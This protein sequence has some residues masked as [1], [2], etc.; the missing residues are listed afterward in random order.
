[1]IRLVLL[2]VVLCLPEPG[3][4]ESVTV[5]SG[6]H[7]D[8]TR[9]FLDFDAGA[10]WV[11]GQVD[12]GFEFRPGRDDIAYDLGRA[13]DRIPRT[14]I[15]AIEDRG[16]GRLYLAV[17]CPCHGDAFD[18]RGGRVVLDI[19]D[20]PAPP[21]ASQFQIALPSVAP[22]STEPAAAP[23]PAP[24]TDLAA[25]RS[26][27]PLVLRDRVEADPW[28][29]PFQPQSKPDIPLEMPQYERDLPAPGL[30]AAAPPPPSTPVAEPASRIAETEAALL[31]QIARA[32]AQGLVEADMGDVENSIAAATH[33]LGVPPVTRTQT[34]STPEPPP[35]VTGRGHVSVSTSLDRAA[36]PDRAETE[37][38]A[39][40]LDPVFFAL[41]GWGAPIAEGTE[42]GP[43]RARLL[44]EFDVADGEGV[45]ELAR[46]YVYAGFGAEAI[47][48]I[49]RHPEDVVR[50][51]L[52]TAMAQ[53]MDHGHADP[54]ES[55]VDQMI[56]DGATALWAVL[57]Q[58]RLDG[59]QPINR[60]AV[61]LAFGGLPPHLRRHLGPGLADRFLNAGDRETAESLHAAAERA[62]DGATPDLALL[63]ARITRAS[64]DLA[65]AE[66]RLDA[67]IDDGSEVLPEAVLDRIDATLERGGAVPETTVSLV[68]S[69]LFERR[70]TDI[71]PRLR[72]A[73]IRALASASLFDRAFERV[74]AARTEG[75]LPPETVVDLT[76][77]LFRRLTGDASDAAFLRHVLTM[78]VDPAVLPADE[79]RAI[80]ARLL[81]L[82]FAHHARDILNG[83]GVLPEPA[84]RLLY[85]RA[86]LIEAKPKVAV[87]YLAGLD[88]DTAQHLR[89]QAMAA[90]SD[91]SGAVAAF[92]ALGDADAEAEAA[93]LGGLWDQLETGDDTARAAVARLML[94]NPGDDDEP[95]LPPLAR[96]GALVSASAEMRETLGR[97]L[98]EVPSPLD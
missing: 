8:F 6:E 57:A 76:A 95:R 48:V 55:L 98:A 51:D 93:W 37:D 35:P 52:L 18:L 62:S 20:G 75:A 72:A 79:R 69:L 78:K 23:P 3:R 13:F 2:I 63:S 53:I 96:S 28:P 91:H 97:V 29:L 46:Y 67:L 58:P 47:A 22:A 83:G 32:A 10:D 43:Y 31:E 70:G 5:R 42:I 61:L 64:G 77:E 94:R 84:D 82:G 44:R 54:A 71:E 89:A 50:G 60:R 65:G 30:I 68:E 33:P 21:L 25:G 38:G 73:Q 92:R 14:R 34:P 88:D 17:D 56:C 15:G 27:L 85:A 80:A 24:P 66:T 11:F 40:C 90:A 26:G 16:G 4:A 1:M 39:R 86:A 74:F 81:D 12:G 49:R 19:K 41:E 87:G 7:E 36:N 59:G 9:I 45:T